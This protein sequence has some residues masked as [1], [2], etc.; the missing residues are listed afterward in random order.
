MAQWLPPFP[1]RDRIVFA[2]DSCSEKFI[3]GFARLAVKVTH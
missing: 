2:G 1:N 3:S